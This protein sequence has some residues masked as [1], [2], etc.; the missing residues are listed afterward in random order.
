MMNVNCGDLIG[1]FMIVLW[2]MQRLRL[3]LGLGSIQGRGRRRGEQIVGGRSC[4]SIVLG[5]EGEVD[6]SVG[7]NEVVNG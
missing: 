6:I 2:R 5:K 4:N 7:L 3:G 1:Q